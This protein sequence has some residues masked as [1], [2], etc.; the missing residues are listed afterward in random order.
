MERNRRHYVLLVN[1]QLTS[2]IKKISVV[3]DCSQE[4]FLTGTVQAVIN[5]INENSF[6]SGLLSEKIKAEINKL[7]TA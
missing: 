2:E 7:K 5:E 3:F 4:Q 1:K 6:I